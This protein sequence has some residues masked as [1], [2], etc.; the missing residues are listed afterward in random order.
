MDVEIAKKQ[1]DSFD[2]VLRDLEQKRNAAEVRKGV[3]ENEIKKYED[4]CRQHGFEPVNIDQYLNALSIEI[5]RRVTDL[6]GIISGLS[7]L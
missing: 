3:L 2:K 7:I 5:D 4:T 1:L 6:H